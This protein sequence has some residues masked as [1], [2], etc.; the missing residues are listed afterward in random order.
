MYQKGKQ[1]EQVK[2]NNLQNKQRILK[3]KSENNNKQK[4]NKLKT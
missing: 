2:N 3:G 1:Q 4:N